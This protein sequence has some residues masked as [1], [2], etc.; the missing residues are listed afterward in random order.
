MRD[1]ESLIDPGCAKNDTEKFNSGGRQTIVG[2]ILYIQKTL[3][4]RK[5]IFVQLHLLFCISDSGGIGI[6]TFLESSGSRKSQK[7]KE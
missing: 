7:G 2:K 6:A 1:N 4:T 3:L 5:G